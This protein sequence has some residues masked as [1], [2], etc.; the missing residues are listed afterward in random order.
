MYYAND[1]VVKDVV[2]A[3]KKL[4]EILS[5]A[6]WMEYQILKLEMYEIHWVLLTWRRIFLDVNVKVGIEAITTLKAVK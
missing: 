4:N 1:I 2:D 3:Q 6:I 5:D